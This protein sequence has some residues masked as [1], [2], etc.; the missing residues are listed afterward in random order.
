MIGDQY[1]TPL[2][3]P[4]RPVRDMSMIMVNNIAIIRKKPIF[5]LIYKGSTGVHI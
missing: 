5:S 4:I 2:P 3:A 1:S